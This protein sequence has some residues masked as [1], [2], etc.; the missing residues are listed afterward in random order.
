[1]HSPDIRQTVVVGVDGSPCAL[2]AVRWGAAEAARRRITL[3]LVI[4]FGWPVGTD[5]AGHG[6]AYVDV[7]TDRARI[8]LAAAVVVAEQEAPGIEVEH[9]LVAGSALH[10]LEVESRHAQ[11]VVIGDRGL[12]RIEGLLLGSVTV[13]LA[14]HASCPVVVVRGPERDPAET[15]LLP[16]VVG[17][18]GTPAG[19]PTLA[20][21]FEAAAARKV[22]L[23]AAHTWSDMAFDPA[24]AS[25]MVSWPAIE[26][27]ES[28]RLSER[29]ARWSEKFP[30]VALE[31]QITRDN[32]AH[33]LLRLAARA[34]LIVVGSRGRGDF[35]GV[36]LGSVS[37]ALLHK[38]PC[39]V[40][41][42]RS[43]VGE[44]S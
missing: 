22:P 21:A 20:F 37:N 13:A 27:E 32:P 30:D 43:H 3:R 23:I 34:Q 11:L 10:V 31:R 14:T 2:R 40:A 1:M 29:L 17:V 15:A 28:A 24:M 12:S 39:P 4:A 18:D 35:A 42:V 9:E 8:Q 44:T 38:A 19:D 33:S 41:V 36:V 7:M 6:N 26:A 25:V 16:I 5:R